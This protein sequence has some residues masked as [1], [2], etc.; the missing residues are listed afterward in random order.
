MGKYGLS[1]RIWA[2]FLLLGLMGQFAWTIENMYFNLFLYDTIST[3]PNYIAE[4]VAASAVA[5]TLTTLLMGAW[6]DKAG[7]RKAFICTGFIIWGF[8]TGVFGFIS[9]KNAAAW[10]PMW[11]SVAAAATLV[12]VMDCVMTFFGSTAYDS[13]FNAYVTD[14]TS[15]RNRGRVE[16]VLAVLPLISMLVIF[17]LFDP[18]TRR[19][20]WKE[21][22]AIFGALVSLAGV[23][24]LFLVRD[25]KK[26]WKQDSF[27]R[28]LVYGFRPSVMRRNPGLY[29]ALCAFCVFSV[30]VQIFF[31]YLIIYLENY[32]KIGNYAVLLGIVLLVASAVSVAGGSFIDR[33]GKLKFSL[34]ASAVMLAGLLGMFFVRGAAAV[35]VAGSVMMSGYML[36]TASL[37]AVIRDYTPPDKAGHFQGIRMIF[38]VMLPMII[39]PYIGAAVIQNS[40][41]TYVD[42]GVVK[43]V[44]TPGIF[45]AAAF[46]LLFL[47]A[48]VL[49]LKRREAAGLHPAA[50]PEA[51]AASEKGEP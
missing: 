31:P 25:K 41:N 5:A 38:A 23:A 30:S 1:K 2:S 51:L 46:A 49:L 12:V 34:P 39:G 33:V 22:F 20:Q 24:A 8:T 9:V 10:F 26:G 21:F 42:L 37:S 15:P 48:P 47:A 19:G 16:S 50:A 11:N 27:F 45:L 32:L 44:P 18:M 40:K 13:T 36:V 4:M 28:N 35:A 3:N 6:S 29:L 7:R 14:V 43:Q 17:G